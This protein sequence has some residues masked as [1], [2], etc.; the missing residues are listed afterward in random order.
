[1]LQP[2]I[3]P[4]IDQAIR[5]SANERLDSRFEAGIDSRRHEGHLVVLAHGVTGNLDRP[6]VADT[7]DALNESGYDTLRF[8]FAGNGASEGDFRAATPTKE[9][10]DLRAVIDAAA[11]AGYGHIVVVG[12]SMGAAVAVMLASQDPRIRALVSLAGMVDTRRFALAEFGEVEPDKGTMWDEP[13]CPLSGA[14]MKDLCETIGS[15]L[16]HAKAVTVPWLLIHGT[17]DDVVLPDDSK[18]VRDTRGEDVEM[19][20]IEGADHSFNEPSHKKQMISAL[21]KWLDKVRAGVEGKDSRA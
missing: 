3:Y 14:F 8:S 21:V 19:V 5:N 11:A 20:L 16:P 10:D 13:E 1:M 18:L 4:M 7:A 2:E 6:V 15:V 9:C 17:A 12:H